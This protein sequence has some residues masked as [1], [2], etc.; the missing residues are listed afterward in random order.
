MPTENRSADAR[1]AQTGC[2]ACPVTGCS[3]QSAETGTIS[4]DG[5]ADE[6]LARQ[7]VSPEPRDPLG[8]GEGSTTADH[9]G[10]GLLTGWPFAAASLGVFLL[11]VLLGVCGAIL[12]GAGPLG[13]A[14]GALLGLLVGM[15]GTML[16]ARLVW[17]RS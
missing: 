7:G 11:P 3:L 10:S 17:S 5:P 13:Q 2:S 4:L 14:P 6:G 8:S 15:G 16:I 12:G 1:L 9:D